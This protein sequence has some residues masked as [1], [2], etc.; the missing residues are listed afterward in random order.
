MAIVAARRRGNP[1][2]TP[3]WGGVEPP[4]LDGVGQFRPDNTI[5]LRPW[6]GKIRKL[7]SGAI[8]APFAS[9]ERT[10]L[11]GDADKSLEEL[12]PLALRTWASKGDLELVEGEWVAGKDGELELHSAAAPVPASDKPAIRR[13]R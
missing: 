5:D 11:W 8:V 6:I 12:L 1:D 10:I 7:E 4:L 9:G 2:G 3:A 13:R